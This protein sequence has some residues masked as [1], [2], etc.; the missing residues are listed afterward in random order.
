MNQQRPGFRLRVRIRL[1]NHTSN[2]AIEER[3][4]EAL[5]QCAVPDNIAQTDAAQVLGRN[6]DTPQTAAQ[7]H[8]H[9]RN[10]PGFDRKPGD[11]FNES[12]RSCRNRQRALC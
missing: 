5:D 8:L 9:G 2:A 10:L 6:P 1:P 12:T 7:R 11:S 4:I 3:C